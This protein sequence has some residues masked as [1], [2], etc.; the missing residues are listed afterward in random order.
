MKLFRISI[1]GKITEGYF[2]S[3]FEALKWVMSQYKSVKEFKK[4]KYNIVC[5]KETI[6]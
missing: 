1:S 2:K 6:N 5:L 3:T 4:N